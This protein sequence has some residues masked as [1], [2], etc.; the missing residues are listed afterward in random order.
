MSVPGKGYSP[1]PS[2]LAPGARLARIKQ[3]QREA[4]RLAAES[5]SPRPSGVAAPTQWGQS[6]PL[7]PAA[8]VEPPVAAPAPVLVPAPEGT[9]QRIPYD[10]GN[11]RLQDADGVPAIR[12]DGSRFQ[13]AD[14]TVVDVEGNVLGMTAQ[15]DLT[16]T[17]ATPADNLDASAVEM[18]ETP[19]GI[20]PNQKKV[21]K[22]ESLAQRIFQATTEAPGESL[23]QGTVRR[24]QR[25]LSQLSP[26]EQARVV[27]LISPDAPTAQ[28]RVSRL[29]EIAGEDPQFRA[30]Q[31][32]DAAASAVDNAA[33]PTPRA[34]APQAAQE[35]ALARQLLEESMPQG[36]WNALTQV[37]SQLPPEQRAAVLE[38]LSAVGSASG[39]AQNPSQA[40]REA[41][42]GASDPNTSY[43]FVRQML[44]ANSDE[45]VFV[46]NQVAQSLSP[47]NDVDKLLLDIDAAKRAG[48]ADQQA[49]LSRELKE[50]IGS[51]QFSREQVD[52]A[53]KRF[54]LRRQVESELRNAII[55]TDELYAAPQGKLLEA[56]RPAPQPNAIPQGARTPEVSPVVRD[57]FDMPRVRDGADAEAA[58]RERAEQA[59]TNAPL[60]GLTLQER[61]VLAGLDPADEQAARKLPLWLKGR[62]RADSMESRSIGSRA[63]SLNTN[64]EAALQQAEELQ[65]AIDGAQGELRQAKYQLR[66]AQIGRTSGRTASSAD[67]VAAMQSRVLEMQDV[68]RRLYAR[69]DSLFRPRLVNNS[70][71]EVRAAPPAMVRDPS[72]VPAGFV[73][74]RG[75][76]AMTDSWLNRAGQ[77]E[78]YDGLIATAVGWRPKG[79]DNLTRSNAGMN[80]SDAAAIREDAINMFGE[81]AA[82]LMDGSFDPDWSASPG[83]LSQPSAPLK[84]GNLGGTQQASRFRDAIQRIY[85]GTN[86]LNLINPRT[87]KPFT[88]QEVAAETLSRNRLFTDPSGANHAMARDR[89]AA[90]IEREF[91]VPGPQAAT[92]APAAPAS[93]PEVAPRTSQDPE[94]VPAQQGA[95]P[96]GTMRQTAGLGPNPRANAAGTS[97]AP[98]QRTDFSQP[99]TA[100][101]PEE[102]ALLNSNIRLDD[103]EVID[104]PDDPTAK[105]AAAGDTAEVADAPDDKPRSR[106]RRRTSKEENDELVQFEQDVRDE[107]RDSG[108]SDDEIEQEVRQRVNR[109]R[110]ELEAETS[111]AVDAADDAD[112]VDAPDDAPS[113]PA[114]PEPSRPTG[115]D[116][117]GIVDMPSDTPAKPKGDGSGSEPPDGPT[118]RG[119]GSDGPAPTPQKRRL[120]WKRAALVGAGTLAYLYRNAGQPVLD[121][122]I[123]VPGEGGPGGGGSGGGGGTPY[124]PVGAGGASGVGAGPS[125]PEDA[126][127]RALERLRGSRKPSG[128]PAYNTMF[129]YTYRS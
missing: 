2:S 59:A 102:Q 76:P 112:V 32:I 19:K 65:A 83:D 11:G 113:K 25:E 37:F 41:A 88:P 10:L 114:S 121:G 5:A 30:A 17:S 107:Y 51:G 94:Q 85:N 8:V 44:D 87:R 13:F 6:S 20:R 84:D 21:D 12:L 46:P 24:L 9:P 40:I 63:N 98:A 117:E 129:N 122:Q 43:G 72:L 92:N 69:E 89:L 125:S 55:G 119:E 103:P 128:M 100:L 66:L 106:G 64:D 38:R 75:R 111:A 99:A 18:D 36:D 104:A 52:E 123:N 108:L 54:M 14:G 60:G 124:I 35:A 82:M 34:S 42:R 50:G 45:L 47:V 101:S 23:S 105:P 115:A 70:T 28:A 68:L 86:P 29:A 79:A 15:G 3:M 39:K 1:N 80:P 22:L 116:G 31:Q 91:R 74:E 78:T 33:R 95:W 26:E 7:P 57:E 16:T 109:R 90:L 49:A 4:S 126:I 61:I 118:P 120:P 53:S 81:D 96:E 48:N 77:S 27:S 73:V 97:P 71:G 127:E 58:L 110:A 56:A 93:A 62:D 67:D